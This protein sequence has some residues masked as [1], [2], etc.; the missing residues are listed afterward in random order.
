MWLALAV[1]FGVGTFAVSAQ[2]LDDLT[3]DEEPSVLTDAAFTERLE[4]AVTAATGADRRSR[5]LGLL[6]DL[7]AAPELIIL[8]AQLTQLTD[9]LATSTQPGDWQ[10]HVPTLLASRHADAFSPAATPRLNLGIRLVVL[11]GGAPLAVL[12]ELLAER[13]ARADLE[14]LLPATGRVGGAAALP[15]LRPHRQDVAIIPLNN[16]QNIRRVPCAA[17]L[18]AAYAGDTDALN[19]VLRWYEADV[20][21]LPRFAFYVQ[22]AR[23][24]GQKPDTALLAYCQHRL[25][26]AERLLRSRRDQLLVTGL[27]QQPA[28]PALAAFFVRD[29]R[30]RSGA[31]MRPYLDLLAHPSIVAR[32]QVLAAILAR[33]DAETK[34]A[35]LG[36]VRAIL[37]PA[38]GTS[39]AMPG[40]M[41]RLFAA[42]ALVLLDGSLPKGMIEREPNPAVRRK[43]QELA[44]RLAERDRGSE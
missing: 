30:T 31:E 1:V 4:Q 25:L 34:S 9:A 23:R 17:V 37:Q 26:Q 21:D 36:R 19:M 11:G 3:L 14:W 24:E 18:G 2:D 12:K 44:Q 41:D 7:A 13:P 43:L 32:H 39:Q 27:W 42:E 22:W 40:G 6:A 35:A 29:L 28:Y 33:G 15:L 8:P 38:Y 20:K 10:E 16:G 5:L